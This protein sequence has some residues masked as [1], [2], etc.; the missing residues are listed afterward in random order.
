MIPVPDIACPYIYL[1][2]L[3]DSGH[4]V[5]WHKGKQGYIF[6]EETTDVNH[7]EAIMLEGFVLIPI[8]TVENEQ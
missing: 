2:I 7:P 4:H 1:G 3:P 5:V 8:N 6:L